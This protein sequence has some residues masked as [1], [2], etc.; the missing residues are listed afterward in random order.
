MP[1]EA[2]I[3]PLYKALV[4][5]VDAKGASIASIIKVEQTT[6]T[7]YLQERKFDSMTGKELGPLLHPIDV[8][9]LAV[10]GVNLQSEVD[11]IKD[12]EAIIATV[13]PSTPADLKS[14]IK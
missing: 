9:S 14:T 2:G 10:Q 5:Q 6:M 13:T 3:V 4:N 11:I 7:T 8:P 1:I 12:L